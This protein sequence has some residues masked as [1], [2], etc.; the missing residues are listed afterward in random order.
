ME[1]TSSISS[2]LFCSSGQVELSFGLFQK[3]TSTNTTVYHQTEG[4]ECMQNSGR[5]NYTLNPTGPNLSSHFR[6]TTLRRSKS[7]F[8]TE[9]F[10]P[11]EPVYGLAFW[12]DCRARCVLYAHAAIAVH[13][14]ISP[15]S[16]LHQRL[17]ATAPEFICKKS[18]TECHVGTSQKHSKHCNSK[19]QA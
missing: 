7:D 1:K 13:P 16:G 5:Q 18:S 12:L 4:S 2:S 3:T 6:Q 9:I 10:I 19:V 14:A 8:H 15:P 11:R 17:H